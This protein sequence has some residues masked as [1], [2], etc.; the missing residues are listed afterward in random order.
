MTPRSL[1]LFA[2]LAAVGL[3]AAAPASAAP[4]FA[5]P[6][7]VAAHSADDGHGHEAAAADCVTHT[8]T[9]FA[10]GTHTA[11]DPHELSQAQ[12]K[13]QESALGKAL[14]AKGMVVTKNGS[15]AKASPFGAQTAGSL[16]EVQNAA[17][18]IPVHFH[19]ITSTTGAG[20][21]SATQVNQQMQ[22]LNNAFASTNISFTLASTDTTANR[23]WY[24]V[25]PGSTS[26]VAMKTA[27][28]K[29]DAGDLNIYSANIGQGLLGWATFPQD[30]EGSQDGV[31]L[32]TG[33]L[34]GG[35]A[36]P[37]LSL[38]HI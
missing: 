11:K 18:S 9:A 32:K 23:K 29:G 27:L 7:P 24:T 13:A 22:V 35:S 4:I 26:E 16:V 17:I 10:R 19:V 15:L 31:V 30:N 28:H 14:A 38:I 20:K 5:A 21:V 37:Y 8:D 34:P 2:P 25:T 3:L 6:A 12:V 33:S 1:A 36:A